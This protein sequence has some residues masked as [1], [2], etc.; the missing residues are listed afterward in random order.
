MF[1]TSMYGLTVK[2][3]VFSQ[4]EFSMRF[5]ICVNNSEVIERFYVVKILYIHGKTVFCFIQKFS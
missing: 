1:G 5:V 4:I 3:I 2:I